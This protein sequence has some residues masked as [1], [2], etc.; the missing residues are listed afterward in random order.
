MKLPQE[1]GEV[2]ETSLHTF[3]QYSAPSLK[4]LIF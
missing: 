3:Q 1:N 2:R 4:P